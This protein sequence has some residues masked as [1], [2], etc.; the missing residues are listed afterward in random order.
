MESLTIRAPTC[1]P[2]N[3]RGQGKENKN[4][5]LASERWNLLVCQQKQEETKGHTASLLCQVCQSIK[6]SQVATATH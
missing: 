6:Q 4:T 2:E 5:V 3:T 1:Q